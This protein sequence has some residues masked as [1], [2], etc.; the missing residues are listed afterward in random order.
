MLVLKNLGS[1]RCLM[2]ADSRCRSGEECRSILKYF[3]GWVARGAGDRWWKR[4]VTYGVSGG[5]LVSSLVIA[6]GPIMWR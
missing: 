5:C 2:M 4:V 6:Y 3:E 1:Q